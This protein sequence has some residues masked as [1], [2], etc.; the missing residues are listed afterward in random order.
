[1][2]SIVRTL[3]DIIET[4]QQFTALPPTTYTDAGLSASSV[5]TSDKSGSTGMACCSAAI[6]VS[7]KHVKKKVCRQKC[8]KKRNGHTA[9]NRNCNILYANINGIKSKADSVNQIVVEQN[10][11]ILLICG[12]I[13]ILQFKLMAS[14]HFL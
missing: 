6:E 3:N 10:I 9:D 7:T 2:K 14:S 8:R 4:Q 5:H 12:T 13:W 1:M 11:D